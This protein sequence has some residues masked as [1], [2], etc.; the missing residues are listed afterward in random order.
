MRLIRQTNMIPAN[1][2]VGFLDQNAVIYHNKYSDIN[3]SIRFKELEDGKTFAIL[4]HAHECVGF[5][6]PKYI[7]SN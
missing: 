1:G 7:Y 3:D 2:I 4:G 5:R 6:N